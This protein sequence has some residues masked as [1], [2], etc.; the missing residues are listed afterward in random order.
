MELIVLGTSAAYP[1]KGKA[2]SGYL[3][4]EEKTNLLLDCGTGVLSNLFRWLNPMDLNVIVITHLHTDHFLDIYPLRYF[5]QYDS[6]PSLPLKV[7]AP[8]GAS[9]FICQLISKKGKE[10]FLEL[11]AFLSINEKIKFEIGHLKLY[12]HPVPH[13]IPTFGVRVEGERKLAYSSD[14]SYH[15]SLVNLA[16]G[17]DM[18]ICEATL[19][20]K[21]AS[22]QIGHLTARQ[23][24]E[25]AQQAKVK[26]LL[27]TH[28]W[29]AYDPLISKAE[30]QEAF[31]GEVILA[32]ENRRY[33]V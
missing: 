4:K 16:R 7:L 10:Q 5:L 22:L 25:I 24:G 8:P 1:Y 32:E 31:D 11:F 9:D 12:F 28:I 6:I 15:S 13:L 14:C 2:C 21:D 20:Q 3:I 26:R 23:A 19:Q 17:A 29:P 30:A 33:E 27:L 18:F